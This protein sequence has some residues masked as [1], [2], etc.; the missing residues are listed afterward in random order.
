MTYKG[1]LA[2]LAFMY[3]VEESKGKLIVSYTH[4]GGSNWPQPARAVC[5][6][7]PGMGPPIHAG[8]DMHPKP[9]KW[10]VAHQVGCSHSTRGLLGVYPLRDCTGRVGWA[11][12]GWGSVASI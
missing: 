3:V 8:W 9:N 10:M 2:Q 7:P 12:T 1:E 11:L 6:P 4:I 5:L